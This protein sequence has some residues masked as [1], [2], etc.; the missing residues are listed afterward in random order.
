[1]KTEGEVLRG[2][3]VFEKACRNRGLVLA[4]HKTNVLQGDDARNDLRDPDLEAIRY[5]W[6][7]GKKE[8]ARPLL[9]K[10]LK[11]A[12]N[13]RAVEGR[14]AKFSLW[15]LAQL[16]DQSL[17]KKVI[18]A[19]DDLAPLASVVA[20]YLQTLYTKPRVEQGISDFLHDSTRNRSP[21]LSAWLLAAMLD[22]PDPLPWRWTAYARE[23]AK[24]SGPIYQRVMAVNVLAKGR[25]ASDIQWLKEAL[26]REFNPEMARGL[27]VALAR[28]QDLPKWL[29]NNIEA[30]IPET[31]RTIVYLKGRR[32]LP[33]LI[34]TDRSNRID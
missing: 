16:L 23:V 26:N 10:V 32:S 22:A 4:G 28:A 31:K 2:L 9:R 11:S 15:R 29:S 12:L 5:L 17:V 33:S 8:R 20:A 30:R 7:S 1:A 14:R 19:L 13:R 34:W 21:F 27:L 25:Q 3:S 18:E 6:E 24:S